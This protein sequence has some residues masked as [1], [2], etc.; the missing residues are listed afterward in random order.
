MKVKKY[1]LHFT[2]SIHAARMGCDF[3][4]LFAV[5]QKH[6]F[7]STQP[8]WA[9][10]ISGNL[11]RLNPSDFNPRSPNGLRR[12]TQ[13]KTKAALCI[14]QSTQPEWAATF[15]PFFIICFTNLISI[16]AARMGCD[17]IDALGERMQV[18]SIHAARMGCDPF[19]PSRAAI[20]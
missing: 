6:I 19:A 13:T 15:I 14:F 7:Q 10:T 2:I 9:A 20:S 12:W 1:N 18:I 8:E 11:I 4:A 3:A 16:H 5:P 17:V